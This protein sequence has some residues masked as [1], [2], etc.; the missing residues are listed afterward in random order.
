MR[1]YKIQV[2]IPKEQSKKLKNLRLYPG[3]PA[4]FI[5][6]QSRTLLNYLFTLLQVL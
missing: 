4:V 2:I 1:Y 5:I 6:T 3:M